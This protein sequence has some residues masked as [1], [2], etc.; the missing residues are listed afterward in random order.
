RQE[1][2]PADETIDGIRVLRTFTALTH[3]GGPLGR[4]LSFL[5]FAVSSLIAALRVRNVDLVMG[6]SPPIFQALS[7]WLVAALRRRPLLLEI[8]DL[9]PE[10]AVDMGVLKNPVLIQLSRWLER[11]LYARAD[12]LLVNS[13]AY[14]DYLV[15]KG[16][17]PEKITLV[18]NGVDPQMFDPEAKGNGLRNRLNLDGKFVVVYAGAIGP[19]NDLSL[20]LDAAVDLKSDARICFLIVGD[21][22]ER[23][24]LQARA[25]I[26]HLDNVLFTG[27][28]PK[29]EMPDYLAGADACVAVLQ[30]IPMFRMTYPNKVFDYMAAGRPIVLAIDGVIREVVEAARAGIF[31]P[32]GDARALAAAVRDLA[33]HRDKG[34][35]M[36]AHGRAY[37]EQHFNRAEQCRHF[38]RLIETL[39]ARN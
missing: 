13:P 10:F 18:A 2:T 27:A 30:D 39:V 26:D 6:T 29:N 37:V 8:R 17:D 34:N 14:V 32:P 19:A 28:R 1:Q 15:K 23:K 12:H 5:S 3:L 11:F 25:E 7:A 33:E 38:V 36:S 4:V 31:V 16:V 35:A 20:L 21:G 24:Q 9:W 22:R